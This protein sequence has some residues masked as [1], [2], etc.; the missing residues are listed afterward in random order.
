[1]YANNG[2][3]NSLD[4]LFVQ[5]ANGTITFANT[6][7]TQFMNESTTAANTI[8][9]QSMNG[10]TAF[11]NTTMPQSMNGTKNIKS[12]TS[13]I[14]HHLNLARQAVEL[15]NPKTILEEL[16]FIEQQIY[17]ISNNATSDSSTMSDYATNELEESEATKEQPEEVE[18]SVPVEEQLP[19]SSSS[20]DD[21]PQ[22]TRSYQ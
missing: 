1:M 12:S 14:I 18:E 17:F 9:P 11:A 3:D 22:R 13:D 6:T 21:T 16:A 4:P 15:G 20:R 19:R 2:T 7:G 10:T 8:M 5:P